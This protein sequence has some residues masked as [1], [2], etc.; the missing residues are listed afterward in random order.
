M[1]FYGI[2]DG[3]TILTI[4]LSTSIIELIVALLDTPFLYIARKIS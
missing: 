4:A 2:Y 1:A 3:K